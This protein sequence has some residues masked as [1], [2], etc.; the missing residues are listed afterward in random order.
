MVSKISFFLGTTAYIIPKSRKQICEQNIIIIAKQ[1]LSTAILGFN[2]WRCQVQWRAKWWGIIPA[3]L[4]AICERE[5]M[6][7]KDPE[8]KS[9]LEK[10]AEKLKT[11]TNKTTQL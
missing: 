7:Q 11:A 6:D 5:E 2:P 8:P 4:S 10:R 3:P 1:N 9:S